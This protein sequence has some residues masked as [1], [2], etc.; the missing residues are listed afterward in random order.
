MYS[1]NGRGSRVT[2]ITSACVV[3]LA[4]AGLI[5][6]EPFEASGGEPST[7]ATYSHGL[8]HVS[9]PYNLTRPGTGQLSMEVLD[10]DDNNDPIERMNILR[11]FSSRDLEKGDWPGVKL[12]RQS[13]LTG[14]G[15]ST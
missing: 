13:P 10:P 4:I 7:S 14:K 9:I 11:M 15:R 8:L 5:C 2:L 1:G 3:A 12:L 6:F